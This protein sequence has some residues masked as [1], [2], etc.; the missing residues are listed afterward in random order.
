M[1]TSDVC[2]VPAMS[3][4]VTA[5]RT[6][7]CSV[8]QVSFH[9]Y[10]LGSLELMLKCLP[11]VSVVNEYAISMKAL[12]PLF[13]LLCLG[14]VE[15]SVAVSTCS[16]QADLQRVDVRCVETGHAMRCS[17]NAAC[18]DHYSPTE[19]CAVF[20]AQHGLPWKFARSCF[21]SSSSYPFIV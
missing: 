7:T 12:N 17:Q 14:F 20:V 5:Y 16:S 6:E 1:T 15:A 2:S 4:A 9:L 18:A 13:L 19:H 21:S 11:I 3:T 8:R 10:G